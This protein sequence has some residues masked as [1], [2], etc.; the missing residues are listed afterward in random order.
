MRA[1]WIVVG[2]ALAGCGK[3]DNAS[4]SNSAGSGSA[5]SGSA[6]SGSAVA[7]SAAGS[8]PAG[9]A[10]APTCDLAGRYR[11]RFSSNG[12][13]GWWFR[14]TVAGDKATLDEPSGVIAMEPGPLE[15]KTDLATCS[16]VLG[17][18]SSALGDATMTLAVD[19]KTHA[20]TGT[21]VRSKA[22]DDKE[23]STAVAGVH[24]G[25][26]AKG[27]ACIAA[28]IYKLGVD[29]KAAWKN[30]D[31]ED[32]RPC[33][34]DRWIDVFVKVEP[35]GDT[36]AITNRDFDPPY[37]ERYGS[38]KLTKIDECTANLELSGEGYELTAKVTFATD[39]ITATASSVSVQVVED[40]DDGENLWDCVAKDAPLVF[41]RVDKK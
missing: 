11:L 23:K 8:A 21:F 20:V 29:P 22:T 37:G 3:K 26:A 17:M 36:V 9:S 12:S 30:K 18:K 16:L 28:G 2:L 5:G 15:L 4:S 7:G 24:D 27:P 25:A 38:D 6:D 41:T 32:D 34:A 39:K 33:D 19:P 14:F 31:A 1:T 10:A 13:T 35:Y 40:G